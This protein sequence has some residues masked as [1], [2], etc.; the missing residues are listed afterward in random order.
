MT[1]L[2][3]CQQVAREIAVEVP[4]VLVGSSDDNSSLFLGCAQSIGKQIAKAHNWICLNREH[5]FTTYAGIAYYELPTDFN[6][7][8]NSTAWDRSNYERIRGPLSPSEWQ[9]YKSSVL[10]S[11]NTVWKRFRLRYDG[12]KKRFTVHPTPTGTSD[13]GTATASFD[14]RVGDLSKSWTTDQ[15]QGGQVYIDNTSSI[16][17]V[18]SNQSGVLYIDNLSPETQVTS[19]DSYTVGLSADSLVFEYITKNWCKSSTGTEQS[20]IAADSDELILDEYLFELGL[21]YK[22]LNRLGMEHA[23]EKRD[24]YNELHRSIARDGGSKKLTLTGRKRYHLLGPQNVSD[25]GYGS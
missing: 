22:V 9:E 24:F 5:T 21:K 18:S 14:N 11:T 3:S 2:E 17:A 1:I 25:S 23:D 7:F 15:W 12:G 16:G 20:A 10:A 4:S 19:G 13:S 6:H 8:E